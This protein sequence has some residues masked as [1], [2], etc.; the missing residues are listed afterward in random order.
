M[1][2]K[3][4]FT[5]PLPEAQ[6]I[7]NALERDYGELGVAISLRESGD[8][9]WLVEAYFEEES[10][11]DLAA[12]LCDWLSA[13]GLDAPLA[14]ERL[15]DT[16]WVTAGLASLAPIEAGR[17]VVHGS[18]DRDRVPAGRTAIEIDAGLAFGTGHHATTAGCLIVLDR[19]MHA[20]QFRNPLDLGAGSGVLAIALAK[21]L[22]RPVLAT[23][24]DAAS[25][26]VARD[27]ARLN[28]VGN[29]VR[30]VEARGVAHAE[31]RRRAPYDLIVANI[32]A[33]PLCRL[34][35]A[36]APLV[37]KGGTLVLSGLLP[38]QRER[39]VSAYHQQG[40]ALTRALVFNGWAVLTLKRG[41]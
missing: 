25:V 1:T 37:A 29:W 16:D 13:N 10:E 40:I 4:T 18:H 14:V 34:A 8:G 36:I 11:D 30:C 38:R 27:N 12:R 15:P 19:L 20:Q 39:V 2:L 21:T 17:F 28:G 32:L 22:H 3:A 26:R 33:E 41:G 31:I 5:A 35:P 24:I 7:S 6:Q 9:P 23:D